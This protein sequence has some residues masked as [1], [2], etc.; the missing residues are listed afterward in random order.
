MTFFPM[1]SIY[2]DNFCIYC[3]CAHRSTHR[4]RYPWVVGMGKT[5]VWVQVE[6]LISMDYP[7]LF[8]KMCNRHKKV[9]LIKNK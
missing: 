9:I 2:V 7:C 4:I 5:W 6:I 3:T 8:L 1:S